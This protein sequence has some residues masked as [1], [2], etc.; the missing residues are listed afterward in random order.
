MVGTSHALGARPRGAGA[1]IVRGVIVGVCKGARRRPG[2]VGVAAGRG[3][4]LVS[5]IH[6][7]VLGQRGQAQLDFGRLG[8]GR[9]G[10][11]VAA[12]GQ[13]GSNAAGISV[14]AQARRLRGQEDAAQ[15]DG[16]PVKNQTQRGKQSSTNDR[17]VETKSGAEQ[18]RSATYIVEH[19]KRQASWPVAY[20][21]CCARCGPKA[22]CPMPAGHECD[23]D[24]AQEPA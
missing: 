16:Q 4:A 20:Q 13:R 5:R 14:P 23:D 15:H 7:S 10:Q 17:E 19:R 6:C 12:R 8:S 22:G 24:T 3:G 1:A 11:R 2:G 21:G 9:R 18:M